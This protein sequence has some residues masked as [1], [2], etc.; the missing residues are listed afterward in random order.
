MKLTEEQFSQ[1]MASLEC[2]QGESLT[3]NRGRIRVPK[4]TKATIIPCGDPAR[5]E[6]MSVVV[7][8][9]SDTGVGLL[10]AIPLRGGE[11]FILRLPPMIHEPPSAILCSVMYSHNASAGAYSIGGQFTRVLAMSNNPKPEFDSA[12]AGGAPDINHVR[13]VENRLNRLSLG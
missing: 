1:V 10:S 7:I 13:E 6:S 2:A 5:R 12:G 3:E 8:N 11:N 4:G 9:L